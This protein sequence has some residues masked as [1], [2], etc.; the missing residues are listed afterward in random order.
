LRTRDWEI[1]TT[2]LFETHPI[3]FDRGNEAALSNPSAIRPSVSVVIPVHNG[4]EN[5]RRCLAAL[6][7]ADPPPQEIIVVADGAATDGGDPLAETSGARVIRTPVCHGPAHARNLGARA[8]QGE[9]VFFIDSDVMVGPDAVGQVAAAFDKDLGPAA[10]FGSYDDAPAEPN[11]LSQYRNLLHHYVHQTSNEEASTFWS[12]CGAIRRDVFLAVGG[13]NVGYDR[14]AI[15]D[16]ELGY[17]L[18]EAGHRIRLCKTLRAKHLKRWEAASLLRADF[19]YRALPWTDLIIRHRRFINDL[20]LRTSSRVSVISVY[21]LW[22]A[23][24]GAWW[25]PGSLALAGLA[26]L[27]LLALNLPFYRFLLQKRGL[28]FVIRAIPWHWFYYFYSGLAFA[29]GL[30][31]YLFN[32]FKSLGSHSAQSQEKPRYAEGEREIS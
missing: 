32:G 31:R 14:P 8:A 6:A 7:R 2:N 23:L 20:N 29:V 22:A 18:R 19:L 10:L 17:R 11:F 26:A 25:W 3:V 13:F 15:E 4:A 12:G 24:I 5:L 1:A 16:I 21:G 30:G 9:I 27:L 28:W